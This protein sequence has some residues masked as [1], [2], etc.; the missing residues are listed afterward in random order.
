MSK[1]FSTILFIFFI[2]SS[3]SAQQ[4]YSVPR[5][6]TPQRIIPSKTIAGTT[7]KGKMTALGRLPD[8]VFDSIYIP[9]IIFESVDTSTS[10]NSF[11]DLKK[12]TISYAV[13]T[14]RPKKGIHDI[15]E[16]IRVYQSYQPNTSEEVISIF[17]RFDLN[18]S[19]NI[20]LDE[21]QVFLDYMLT[22][23]SYQANN[24][25]LSPSDFLIRR[26]GDCEDFAIFTSDFLTFWGEDSFVGGLYNART[27]H[28]IA[29]LKVDIVPKGYQSIDLNKYTGYREIGIPTGIYIPID[30]NYLGTYSNATEMGMV[31]EKIWISKAII[32]QPL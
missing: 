31:L 1:T 26:G 24:I 27:G 7:I 32:G 2:C 18:G 16:R 9:E 5:V 21:L 11:N 17:I 20:S 10:Y 14:E 23:F 30:Y 12:S 29:L 22:N 13:K 8:I 6:I 15:T 4:K 28:A 25:A 3:I 19:S